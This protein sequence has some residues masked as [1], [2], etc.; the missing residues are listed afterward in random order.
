M[1][2][3]RP[4][5]DDFDVGDE[6]SK[7]VV[8]EVSR[9]DFVKYAGASGDFNPIHYD[10]EAAKEAG[11]P[12]VIAQGM[13]TAGLLETLVTDW[14]GVENVRSFNVR[15]TSVVRPGDSIRAV[16]EVEETTTE[17][18]G[19]TVDLALRAE[20]QSGETVIAGTATAVVPR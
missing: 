6:R 17:S 13:F 20:T 8:E 1:S 2:D 10:D 14:V 18:D 11:H 5:G 9:T 16:G 7:L 3:R 15:F 19:V 4:T 12:G